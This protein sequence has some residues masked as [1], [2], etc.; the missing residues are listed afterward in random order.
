MLKKILLTFFMFL[1]L[2]SF[3]GEL[4][5]AIENE[6]YIF[7]YINS[8]SCRYCLLCNPIYE[9][10]SK[11]YGKKVKFLNFDAGTRYG[12]YILHKYDGMYV[13]YAFL[14][15]TKKDKSYIISPDCVLQYSCTENIIKKIAK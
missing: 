6:D 12:N 11:K 8:S 3:A 1:I 15:N 14:I 10:L 5:N 9:K 13:P 4:E 7:V 2:P